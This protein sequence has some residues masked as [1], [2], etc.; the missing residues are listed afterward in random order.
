M[1]QKMKL[2]AGALLIMLVI[3]L[4]AACSGTEDPATATPTPATEAATPVPSDSTVTDPVVDTPSH[5]YPSY[6]NMESHTPLVLPGNDVTISMMIRRETIAHTDIN[7]NWM[8]TY[9]REILNLNLDIEETTAVDFTE[10]RNLA[11]AADMLP[12]IM[13]NQG[14]S[15]ELMV[16]FGMVERMFLPINQYMSPTLTPNMMGLME[17][18]PAIVAM[19]Q[20]PDGNMY[21]FSN[22][23]ELGGGEGNVWPM[24]VGRVFINERWMDLADIDTVPR[25]IDDFLTMLRAFNQLTPDQTNSFEVTP[26]ISANEGDRQFFLQAMGFVGGGNWGMDAAFN[27]N[28]REVVLPAAQPEFGDL[29]RLYHTMYSE[30]IL[31]I[32]YFVM[33]GGDR[34]VSRAHFAEGNAGVM[35]DAAPYLG[36]PDIE[37]FQEWISVVPMTSAT[38]PTPFVPIHNNVGLG[39]FVVSS[40]TQHPELIMRLLDWM[41]SPEMSFMSSHG[42]IEG[43][44]ETLGVITGIRLNEA[45]GWYH[46]DVA[47]GL[48][49]SDFDFRVNAIALS[50]ETPRNTWGQNAALMRALGIENPQLRVFDMNDGDDHYIVRVSQAHNG[51]FVPVLPTA[52]LQPQQVTRVTDLRA[53]ILAHVQSEFARFVVGQR[54][55]EEVDDFFG[56]LERFGILEL[57]E[58]WQDVF[59]DYMAQRTA[60]TPFRIETGGQYYY[61]AP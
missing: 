46:P 13:I 48:F 1:K 18:F 23:G 35:A 28:T 3:A 12:D 21:S 8:A 51:Y 17:Q 43:S 16:Q 36:I 41:Y 5:D 55:I 60:W 9:I 25:T 58:I 42:P 59:A 44:P 47:S 24:G 20:T 37:G 38:N 30:G 6:I 31:P 15:A 50:Q 53:V 2:L 26:L 54:P 7:T 52:F 56:E 33:A 19:N 22:V 14:I 4:A 40:Q 57:Q 27:I 32:D 49:E 11:I 29:I 61:F 45:G 10:R 39:T 34:A